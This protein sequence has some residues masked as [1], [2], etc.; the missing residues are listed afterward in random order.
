MLTVEDLKKARVGI[1]GFGKEGQAVARFLKQHGLAARVYDEQARSA[2]TEAELVSLEADGFVFSFGEVLSSFD[3][4]TVLFR[5]PGVRRLHPALVAAEMH[6][7]VITSQTKFFFDHCPAPI[8]GI[9]GT[10]GKGT[11]A[12]LIA[13]I[14]EAACSARAENNLIQTSTRIFVTGNIGK[15]DPLDILPLLTAVDIV[16]FELSSFQLQDLTRSPHI[17]VCLMV[18]QEHLDHHADLAEYH[19]AKSAIVA[20]QGTSDFAIY[21]D[22]YPASQAIGAQGKGLKFSFS[23][24]HTVERGAYAEDESVHILGLPENGVFSVRERLLPGAH[25]LENICAASLAAEIAGAPL[26]II[27]KTVVAF[28]GLEHRLEYVGEY[29]KV[30]F[31]NDSISTVPES[32]I[33]ALESF[34]APTVLI[35]GGSEKNSDFTALAERIASGGHVRGVI[36]IGVTA[37]RIARALETA[38][39]GGALKRGATN[40]V[41]IFAQVHELAQPGDVVLLSPACA[42]FGMFKNYKERGELFRDAAKKY[43]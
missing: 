17:G 21:S 28:T 5:S 12:T 24:Y 39:Y 26:S 23:R 30:Q 22:D 11:T 2:F 16:V 31:Y 18:T 3:D 36:L 43:V 6:G 40:M 9:T 20:Y 25:N 34:S 13:G 14:L 8:I 38:G 42:S 41:E 10:K 19:R 37:Q 4:C 33:A 29:G 32:A 15:Q 7:I 1:V 35:L 27:E